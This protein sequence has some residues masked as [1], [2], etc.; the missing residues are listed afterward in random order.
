LI[1]RSGFSD[2]NPNFSLG[3]SS[4]NHCSLAGWLARFG[5]LLTG[6]F[7]I[8]SRRGS[9]DGLPLSDPM[10]PSAKPFRDSDRGTLTN[11]VGMDEHA[12]AAR[13]LPSVRIL[14]F[15]GGRI[16]WEEMAQGVT[17]STAGNIWKPMIFDSQARAC[18]RRSAAP[19]CQ[20][21]EI[22]WRT[23]PLGGNGPGRHEIH[24]GKHV[25]TNDFRPTF[26]S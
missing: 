6:A 2:Q 26:P 17:R 11:S 1:S 19:L 7:Q 3:N 21:P 25:G 5:L 10:E 8:S 22:L 14:K 9:R 16:H 12:D 24:R 4:P 18:R 23:D 20:N 15:F 13:R